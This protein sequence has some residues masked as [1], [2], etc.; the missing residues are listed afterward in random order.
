MAMPAVPTEQRLIT[1]AERLFAEHGTGA[2]S[3]RAVMQAAGTN[4]AAIHYHFGSKEGLVDAVLRSRIDQV[5]AE[6]NAVLARLSEAEVTAC[7]LARA[8]VQ[9]VVAV[10]DSGGEHWLRLVGRLLADG[11]DGLDAIA[12][13][14]LQRNATFVDLLVRLNPGVPRATLDF[15]LTLAMNITLHVLGDV[16]RTRRLQGRDPATWPVDQ[17]VHDLVDVVAAV[18]VPAKPS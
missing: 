17:V 5:G 8:F 10:L 6:R 11:D 4:V 18:L 14:F 12:G 1:A 2:V 9:P 3:L 13:S 15:R 16:E 7:E